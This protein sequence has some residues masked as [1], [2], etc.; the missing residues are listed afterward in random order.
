[1][2]TGSKFCHRSEILPQVENFSTVFFFLSWYEI[3]EFELLMFAEQSFIKQWR[4]Q[5]SN[6]I[7]IQIR[8]KKIAPDFILFSSIFF[9]YESFIS[10][11]S[12]P[13]SMVRSWRNVVWTGDANGSRTK[14]W[15]VYE[16]KSDEGNNDRTVYEELCSRRSAPRINSL[17]YQWS[18]NF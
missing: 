12:W 14:Q 2:V 3:T 16:A 1:M 6:H 11:L 5:R 17:W 9:R 13:N 4:N 7:K 10:V 15:G 18:L 8:P